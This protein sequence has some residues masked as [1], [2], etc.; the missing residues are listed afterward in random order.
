MLYTCSYKEITASL[1]VNMYKAQAYDITEV[2]Q[3]DFQLSAK[4]I[5]I[6]TIYILE[7]DDIVF[8][9]NFHSLSCG[10]NLPRAEFVK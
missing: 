3:M 10:R 2:L 8:I 9:I 5:L 6:G 4:D 1:K 7:G